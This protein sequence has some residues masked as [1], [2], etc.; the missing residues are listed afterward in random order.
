MLSSGDWYKLLVPREGIYRIDLTLLE[1]MGLNGSDIS[2]SRV[3]LF[4]H[5]GSV[6]PQ[7]LME[8]AME[9]V[10]E[11]GLRFVGNGNDRWE[12][13]EYFLFYAPLAGGRHYVSSKDIFDVFPHPY[14]DRLYYYFTYGQAVGRRLVRDNSVSMA[15]ASGVHS[16]YDAVYHYELNK[17]NFVESG[18]R[19]YG[20]RI[21]SAEGFSQS[22][23]VPL[24]P[25][26]GGRVRFRTTLAGRC[27][28]SPC[29][30][31]IGVN[32][33]IIGDI[34]F[35]QVSLLPYSLVAERR[36]GVWGMNVTSGELILSFD[37]SSATSA[38]AVYV[39]DF[40][41]QSQVALRYA[42]VPLFFRLAQEREEGKPLGYRIMAGSSSD[43]EIWNIS[44]ILS[45]RIQDLASRSATALSFVEGKDADIQSEYVLFDRSSAL[46]AGYVKKLSHALVKDG[47]GADMLIITS[48]ALQSEAERLAVFRRKEDGF[49]VR[50]L[51]T[52]HIFD[53]FSAGI[54]DPTAIRNAVRYFHL[55]SPLRLRYV[56]LFGSATYDPRGYAVP[57]DETDVP[58]YLSRESLHPVLTYSS[59]DY[60]G[61]ME[62]SEGIWEE[63]PAVEHTL[64]LG[65]GRIP[66][67][68]LS[69]AQLVVDKIISYTQ[70]P[71]DLWRT[72]LHFVADDGDNN[73]HQF[74]TEDIVMRL[75]GS[76]PDYNAGR[77]YLDDYSQERLG[78]RQSSSSAKEALFRAIERGSLMVNF[79]GHGN[80]SVWTDEEIFNAK[81][82][83]ALSNSDRLSLF[84]TAT[85]EF[86]RH[87]RPR[88]VSEGERLLF[89]PFGGAI[90]LMTASRPVY[91]SANYDLN[92]AF[93]DA[94]FRQ[95]GGR[96]GRLG[97]VMRWTKNNDIALGGN[98]SF[99]L[100]GDP[101]LRLQYPRYEAVITH[102][103]EQEVSGSIVPLRALDRVVLSG[104]IR[105]E[106]GERLSN[107][108]GNLH[109]TLYDKPEVFETLGDESAPFSYMRR[110]SILFR[111]LASIEDGYFRFEYIVPRSILYKE[112]EGRLLMYASPKSGNSRDAIGSWAGFSIGGSSMDIEAD[113]QGPLLTAYLNDREIFARENTVGPRSVLYITAEDA[114]GI[115]LSSNGISQSL[116]AR[117]VGAGRDDYFMLSEYYEAELDNFRK[118]FVE[119]PLPLLE[120]G[121]YVLEIAAWDTYDNFTKKY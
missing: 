67:R 61:F 70:A 80:A 95:E 82:I 85:C 97:D 42:G 63:N 30:V 34:S 105:N 121:G 49:T 28:G 36:E 40:V 59:D 89:H 9:D 20:E 43:L 84:V 6:L 38:S 35:S 7:S 73:A 83:D 68:S 110:H 62:D 101:S 12:A 117:L 10:R 45:P 52:E 16:A 104:E 31:D 114:H 2:P 44:D 92:S 86:G 64:D 75:D 74:N 90:A 53:E 22:F 26:S 17:F 58:I 120:E 41:V 118:G 112:G 39:D 72:R 14:T 113:T 108:D 77:L 107:Y 91:A 27:V 81:S 24:S 3:Q 18:R 109:I 1:K 50:V 19:W 13:G 119:F 100:L 87:D 33:S 5:N 37:V 51:N 56:L 106:H 79:N 32:G 15:Q 93:A 111:G 60:Y 65:V 23:R 4:G 46:S 47:L 71:F 48:A 66:A 57:L 8:A 76:Y 99:I 96:Y 88:S 78:G 69:Q 54:R 103:N 21:S 25:V 11:V 55:L 116:S 29:S 102:F 94:L 98:R 115:R